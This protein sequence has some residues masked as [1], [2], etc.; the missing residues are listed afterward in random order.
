LSAIAARFLVLTLAKRWL[1]Q[2]DPSLTDQLLEELPGILLWALQGPA[3][4]PSSSARP[5]SA[6]QDT[7]LWSRLYEAWRI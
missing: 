2:E 1:G 7:R 3:W 4:S 6:D 5:A